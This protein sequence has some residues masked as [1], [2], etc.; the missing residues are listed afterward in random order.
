MRF[1]IVGRSMTPSERTRVDIG[2]VV[3]PGL[4][5]RGA[6]ALDDAPDPALPDEHVM[7]LFGQHKA[8]GARQRVEPR[9]RQRMQ[10]HLAVAIGEEREHEEG[11]PV[12]GRLVEGAQQA[13]AVAVARLAAQQILG[14]LA[15][16]AA[17]IFLQQID[18]RP[19]V[20]GLLDIDLEQVAQIVERRRG[21]A[22]MALLLDRSR[23][24]VA[25]H[26]DQPPQH[27][28]VFA[29]HLLPGRLA[30]VRAEADRAVLDRPAPAVC[31]SGIPAF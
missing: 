31:P 1:W 9:L 23:L 14:L 27:R 8:A 20:A 26:D 7:R 3:D 16:V 29:R 18:H 22:E 10:L 30:L 28:A 6:G 11:E 15:P 5:H 19:Q 2:R 4:A 13:R 21:A 12:R 17:E 25:L 24:G